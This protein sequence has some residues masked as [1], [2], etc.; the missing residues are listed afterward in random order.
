MIPC[1][2][3]FSFIVI[4][5]S[6][7]PIPSYPSLT[8]SCSISTYFIPS[9]SYTVLPIFLSFNSV[10]NRP[11]LLNLFL[12]PGIYSLS[13]YLFPHTIDILSLSIFKLSINFSG[14][15]C[16]GLSVLTTFILSILSSYFF[17]FKLSK[18]IL[19]HKLYSKLLLA[20]FGLI[21]YRFIFGILTLIT[22]NGAKLLVQINIRILLNATGIIFYSYNPSAIDESNSY[23]EC[24]F[25]FFYAWHS[26]PTYTW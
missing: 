6:P 15:Q 23:Q 18:H 5:L 13:F 22:Q 25:G 3:S 24:L 7:L 9:F 16:F 19:S 11:F 4:S 8:F 26:Y 17:E 10:S 12:F 1:A 20:S 14:W 21:S 2:L